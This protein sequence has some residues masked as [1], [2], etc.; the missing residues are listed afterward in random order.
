MYAAPRTL[1]ILQLG[2][3]LLA[4]TLHAG[5]Q[6]LQPELWLTSAW[7]GACL[8]AGMEALGLCLRGCEAGNLS[9]SSACKPTSTPGA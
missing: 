9:L 1:Q 6:V 7:G 5:Q 3:G 2:D 4:R 8:G